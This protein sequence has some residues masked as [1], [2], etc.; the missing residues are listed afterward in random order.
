M[1]LRMFNYSAHKGSSDIKYFLSK[2]NKNNKNFLVNYYDI[3][4]IKKIIIFQP[5]QEH[6]PSVVFFFDHF[7]CIKELI[8]I[9]FQCKLFFFLISYSG[10]LTTKT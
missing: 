2:K 10:K 5:Y 9:I 8:R 3:I 4:K 6:E 7:I 1:Q